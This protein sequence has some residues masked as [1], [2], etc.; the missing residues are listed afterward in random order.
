M[1]DPAPA[2]ARRAMSLADFFAASRY[3]GFRQK[4]TVMLTALA[5]LATLFEAAGLVLLLPIFQYIQAGSDAAGL[6]QQSSLWAFLVRG[7]GAVGLP[8]SLPILMAM[9]IALIVARQVFAFTRAVATSYFSEAVMRHIRVKGFAAYLRASSGF[10]E[11]AHVGEIV[12][13]LTTEASTAGSAL[14]APARILGVVV[15]AAIYLSTLTVLSLPLTLAT[16]CVVGVLAVMM[17]WIMKRIRGKAQQRLV[18][19]DA[20][21][22]QLVRRLRFARLVR[23]SGTEQAEIDTTNRQALVLER[24]GTGLA[25]LRA[26]GNVL[27][28]PIIAIFGLALMYVA[29]QGYGMS[30][31]EIGLFLL[32]LI[33]LSPIAQAAA[34][35]TQSLSASIPALAA[36]TARIRAMEE[37]AEAESGGVPFA[38]FQHEIRFE[39]VWFR[40]PMRDDFALRGVTL[41][42]RKGALLALV[43][44]SGGGKSTIIDMLFRIRDP[45]TG[46]ILVDGRP[47]GDFQ[48]GSLRRRVAYAPQSPQVLAESV[49]AHIAY[50]NP[51]LTP[52]ALADA[53]ERAGAAAFVKQLPAGFATPLS[54]SGTGL[55]GGQL[56]RVELA[57]VLARNA[58]ILV[59]DEPTGSLDAQS[60]AIFRESLSAMQRI[61]GLTII[62]VAHRL[63]TIMDAD[64][65]AVI[66]QGA[67]A[68]SGTHQSLLDAGGW[69]ARAWR[70]QVTDHGETAAATGAGARR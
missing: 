55:S 68:E 26:W 61:E 48:R 3:L 39:D 43:G 23:I 24:L 59:L 7:F 36:V 18:S 62:V 5:L 28:E 47:I 9:C 49:A 10:Q 32:I 52:E 41:G 22:N 31:G 13:A 11:K 65:I 33:R 16:L 20:W 6:A 4:W 21:F 60:E 1:T 46:R 34:V 64:A 14:L 35:E 66:K 15:L 67:V 38:D 17:R 2:A 58:S 45:A 56:Q 25:K 42:I 29:T 8:V 12:N 50:G 53:A 63:K 69:Y 19:S 44:P 57:R 37:N 51:G 30:L 27:A 54:E 40:Y 70:E